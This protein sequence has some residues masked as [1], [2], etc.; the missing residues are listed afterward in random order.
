MPSSTPRT[1][2]SN[3]ALF[4]VEAAGACVVSVPGSVASSVSPACASLGSK[5]DAGGRLTSS[6][7]SLEG[8]T[9]GT[10]EGSMLGASL[11]SSLG[12]SLGACDSP[13]SFVFVKVHAIVSPTSTS[14]D[15][16]LPSTLYETS[17]S[18]VH[19]MSVSV[20]PLGSVSLTMTVPM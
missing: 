2:T 7:G 17:A 16:L 13:P 9:D 5:L 14:S 15:T 20:H 12:A 3:T 11:G 19:W 8:V 10:T 4:E 18:P 1:T 6:D